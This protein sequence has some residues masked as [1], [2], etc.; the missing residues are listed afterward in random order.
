M[1]SRR[2]STPS[3]STISRC[4]KALFV[5]TLALYGVSGL[6][7][8]PALAGGFEIGENTTQSV[9]R[10]GTGVVS[11]RDPS[12]LYFNPALLPRAKGFQ[13]LLDTNL[14][15]QSV[16]FERD[17]LSYSY[18]SRPNDVT[19]KTFEPAESSGTFPA[20][21]LAATWDLGIEDFAMG[22]GAFGPSAYS[23]QCF[24]TR[25][26]GECKVDPTNAARQMMVNAQLLQIYFTLGAG[27]T[28]RVGG[29]ELGVGISLM[30]AYQD[31]TFRLVVDEADLPSP[32]W[33]ED[34]EA[35]AT[36]EAQK[37]RGWR[38]TGVLGLS[39]RKDGFAVAASYRPPIHWETQGKVKLDLPE[40]LA[41]AAG[42]Q[43]TDDGVTLRTWQAG[44]LRVGAGW[45]QGTHPGFADRPR[46][47][48]EANIVWEDWSR[49][50]YFEVETAGDI[51]LTEFE[52]SE[53]L[54]IST[55][56]Q[57]KQWKDT[58]SVR[59]G[60]SYGILP[61]L[62]GHAGGYLE[63]AT[64]T[65]AYT[66]ADFIAWER[67]GLGLGASFHVTSYLDVELGYMSIFSPDRQVRQGKVYQ[68]IPLSECA[69]PKYDSDKCERA[70]SPPGNPQNEGKWSAHHQ[71]GSLGLTLHLD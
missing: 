39:W 23:D 59:L 50:E 33:E 11:K 47:E 30:A 65:K 27:K 69:G 13:L 22:I 51:E 32:P 7:L 37:L 16:T 29:G 64:Q 34:P 62:T 12:A 41:V 42:A 17:P 2:A 57:D 54:N 8:S 40:G 60:G 43:L 1:R 31:N 58:F 38:P 70:G 35:Q 36:F 18:R 6:G 9:A 55:I 28:F 52:G 56:R 10:G 45:E 4:S 26:D 68:S 49:V 44:S 14:V 25:E 71:I 15:N 24:G 63:T 48:L 46:L 3:H 67:Y 20:P 19:T 66:N 53:P 5:T 21:F 61:W